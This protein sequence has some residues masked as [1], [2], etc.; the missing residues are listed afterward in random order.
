[1][2]RYDAGTAFLPLPF[3]PVIQASHLTKRF[4]DLIAVDDLN[5]EIRQGEF[6]AFLG[7]NAAGKT[8]TIKMLT[9]LLR[10]S[11]GGCRICG[12]DMTD[13]PEAAKSLLAYVPDFPFL[14]DKLTPREFM[15]FVGDLF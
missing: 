13:E 8:T 12:H 15:Q 1:M 7:P 3:R 9:G 11:A 10:P 5:L 6:F 2:S 4:G 14:Y